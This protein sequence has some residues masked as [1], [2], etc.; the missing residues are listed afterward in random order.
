MTC[1]EVDFEG[2]IW[3]VPADRMKTGRAHDV[4]LGDQAV[5]ILRAQDAHAARTR[6]CSPAGQCEDCRT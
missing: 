4:P 6:T 1:D 2:A 3:R 5:A